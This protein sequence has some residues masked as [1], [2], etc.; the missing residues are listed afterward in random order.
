MIP[1]RVK[2]STMRVEECTLMRFRCVP[3]GLL[4]SWV[5]SRLKISPQR[6]KGMKKITG[7]FFLNLFRH[8]LQPPA[9]SC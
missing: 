5:L 9:T 6:K 3:E 1:S 8:V 7:K 2:N 4:D